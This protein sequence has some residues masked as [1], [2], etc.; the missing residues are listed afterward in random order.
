MAGADQ[1]AAPKLKP[2]TREQ[3]LHKTL[4]TT[5]DLRAGTI[6]N[7]EQSQILRFAGSVNCPGKPEGEFWRPLILPEFTEGT[8][9][10]RSLSGC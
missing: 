10:I 8:G 4:D 3:S 7:I 5:G 9:F 1:N 6:D 2:S